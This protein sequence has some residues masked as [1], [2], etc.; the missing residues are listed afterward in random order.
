VFGSSYGE[1]VKRPFSS[2][3]ERLEISGD[4]WVFG[5]IRDRTLVG[6]VRLVRKGGRKER[7]KA[8][9]FGMYVAPS[10][11]HQGV[12]RRMLEA[13]LARARKLKGVK[14]IQLTVVSSNT[15]AM[16][17]YKKAGFVEY[18]REKDALFVS[19]RYHT[20]SLMVKRL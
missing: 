17:L 14:M 9:I 16:D 7:H 3:R 18:G 6:I 5:G 19:G 4:N 1:E 8:S 10:S 20:E 12:A 2:F 11:R 15:A 13:V